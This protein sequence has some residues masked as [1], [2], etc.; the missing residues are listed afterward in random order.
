M[1]A[2]A[3]FAIEI[4]GIHCLIF[5]DVDLFPQN[6]GNYYACSHAKNAA[7]HIG[8][9][10]DSLNYEIWYHHLV[11][12]VASITVENYLRI[13]GYSN[14]F[15]GW[16]GEDDDFGYRLV[17]NDIR[18]ERPDLSVGKMTMLSHVHRTR[19]APSEIFSLLK[20]S[21]ERWKVDGIN[22]TQWIIKK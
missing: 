22:N 20:T 19:S 9:Y 6:D 10:V 14:L 3:K 16:G 12:G 18:I 15:W 4:L 2:A 1:N 11:G 13:N 7:W 17:A 21:K 5:H 8:G